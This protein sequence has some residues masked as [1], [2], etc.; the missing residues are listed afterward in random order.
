MTARSIGNERKYAVIGVNES[1]RLQVRRY[2]PPWTRRGGRDLK[3]RYCEATLLGADGV[4][5][6]KLPIIGHLNQPLLMLRAVALA[7]RARLRESKVASR[8]L[9][10]SRSHPFSKE[11][12]IVLPAVSPIH[13][14]LLTLRSPPA[15]LQPPPFGGD[16]AS[17]MLL[18]PLP[19]NVVDRRVIP[20]FV[21]M[22][23]RA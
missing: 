3:Q 4:V 16:D 7:L 21:A 2:S 15:K 14:H 10:E 20:Q 19:K 9:L 8:N 12:N 23:V 22:D 1:E 5:C 17:S 18:R 13:S 6:S 11:G